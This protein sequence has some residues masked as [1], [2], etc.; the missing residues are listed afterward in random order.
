MV[1]ASVLDP[2]ADSPSPKRGWWEDEGIGF[3]RNDMEGTFQPH[4]DELVVTL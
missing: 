1:V 4:D 2:E 3:T